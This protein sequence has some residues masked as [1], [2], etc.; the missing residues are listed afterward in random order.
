MRNSQEKIEANNIVTN[1]YAK[2]ENEN[3]AT[4][5]KKKSNKKKQQYNILKK[6]LRQQ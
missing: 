5:N 6:Y 2:N 1:L 3:R 4:Q